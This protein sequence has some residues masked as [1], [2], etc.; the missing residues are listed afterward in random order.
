MLILCETNKKQRRLQRER[1]TNLDRLRSSD[2]SAHHQNCEK[3]KN[4][5]IP[6]GDSLMM[7]V[8]QSFNIQSLTQTIFEMTQFKLL[9]GTYDPL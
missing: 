1:L 4:F 8:F 3:H 6:V 2:T 9:C 7:S 5:D